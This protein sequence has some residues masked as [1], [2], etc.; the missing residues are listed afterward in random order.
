[1]S[2]FFLIRQKWVKVWLWW[3]DWLPSFVEITQ[4]F[5]VLTS[6]FINTSCWFY[7]IASTKFC[8]KKKKIDKTLKDCRLNTVRSTVLINT[9]SKQAKPPLNTT[10]NQIT[11][12]DTVMMFR[13]GP[14]FA[15]LEIAPAP[16]RVHRVRQQCSLQFPSASSQTPRPSVTWSRQQTSRMSESQTVDAALMDERRRP[17]LSHTATRR[18]V[19]MAVTCEE[20]GTWKAFAK[21]WASLKEETEGFMNPPKTWPSPVT[22]FRFLPFFSFPSSSSLSFPAGGAELALTVFKTNV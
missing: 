10:D 4:N 14:S 7:N 18:W 21:M 22:F 2:F 5:L 15:W 9:D 11:M 8:L 16:R 19:A 1:M 13:N 20:S 3:S 17:S 12:V 6:V